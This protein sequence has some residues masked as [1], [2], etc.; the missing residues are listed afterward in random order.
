MLYDASLLKKEKEKLFFTELVKYGVKHDKA[1]KAAKILA[2]GL[3]DEL[4]TKKEKQ[5]VIEVCREW[6]I[7]H[8]PQSIKLCH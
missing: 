5:L 1:A 7:K 6:S 3:P 8:K 4:L 2:A